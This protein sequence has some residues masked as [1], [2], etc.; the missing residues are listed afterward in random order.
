MTN[1]A[2]P[3]NIHGK[4]NRLSFKPPIITDSIPV[5]IEQRKETEANQEKTPD[6]KPKSKKLIVNKYADRTADFLL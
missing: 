6:L 3:Q 1:Q 5:L 2:N 4:N